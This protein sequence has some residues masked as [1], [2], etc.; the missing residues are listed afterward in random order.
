MSNKTLLTRALL[1]CAF[2]AL[3]D[4]TVIGDLTTLIVAGLLAPAAILCMHDVV[5]GAAPPAPAKSVDT[6]IVR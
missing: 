5:I 2:L 6:A 3:L 1:A 4:G